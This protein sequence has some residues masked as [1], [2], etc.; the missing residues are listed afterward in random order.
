MHSDMGD[1]AT[2]LAQRHRHLVCFRDNPD[3]VRKSEIKAGAADV[4]IAGGVVFNQR[5]P[6]DTS[7]DR[8]FPFLRRGISRTGGMNSSA[9][10]GLGAP[11]RAIPGTW[12]A[13]H[14]TV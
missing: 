12:N 1:P 4:T 3:Q 2:F 9:D 8:D 13:L 14:A 6:S 11:V 5:R 7:S 10:K